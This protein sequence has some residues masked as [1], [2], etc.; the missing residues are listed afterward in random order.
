MAWVAVATIGGAAL[1]AWSSNKSAKDANASQERQMQQSIDAQKEATKIDPRIEAMLYGNGQTTQTLKQG[2]IPHQEKIDGVTRMVYSPDDYETKT[3]SG[4]LGR[5]MGNLDKS[6]SGG[7]TAAGTAADRY[8]SSN[9]GADLTNIRDASNRLMSGISAPQMNAASAATAQAANNG[10]LQP[11][12]ASTAQIDMPK[13]Y[14]VTKSDLPAAMNAAQGIAAQTTAPQNYSATLAQSATAASPQTMTAAQ[15]L[16]SNVSPTKKYD[17]ATAAPVTVGQTGIAAPSQN[18]LDLKDAYS[19]FINAESGNNP[20]LTGAI[21]KGINQSNNAYGNM[22]Q[23]Q[24]Q[25]VQDALSSIRGGAISSGQYGGSRQGLAESRTLADMSKNLTRAASQYG[26]NNTDAAVAAQAGQYGQ[27]QANKLS[28]LT[29]LGGQ[30]YS[31]AAQNAQMEQAAKMANAQMAM[32]GNQFNAGNQNQA[33]QAAFGNEAQANM[34][35]AAAANS[36][37]QF[38]ANNQ[39][40][41]NQANMQAGQNNAQFNAGQQQQANLTNAA[42]QNQAAQTGYQGLL[43]TELSNT[44]AQNSMTQQNIG[45][46]QNANQTN[47]QGALNNAQYNAAA[48]NQAAQ[49]GYQGNLAASTANAN[50]SNQMGQF[51]AGNQQNANNAMYQGNLQNNQFNAG[52]ANQT[53]Q[54]NATN[55]Q[56]AWGNNLQAQMGTNAQNSQNAMSGAGLLSGQ[57]SNIYNLSNNY[58]NADMAR[59]GQISGLLQPYSGK[60]SPINVPQYQQYTSNPFGSAIGGATAAMG[61]YNA[62]NQP[63]TTTTT[64]TPTNFN[65]MAWVR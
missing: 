23:D 19:Q 31:I 11:S 63:S 6:Q 2:A 58:N 60:G 55:Q 24:T 25:A 36:M 18:S 4:L 33:N 45:N 42:A 57:M 46:Q 49:T 61:L 38:N 47:Y 32:A 29:S 56:N 30:Q 10:Y 15:G 27:D 3:D 43:N 44:A 37:S 53:N 1:G 64:T 51:N 39:N 54:Y 65:P 13:N 62:F 5:I 35:N 7:L 41:A 20:Y 48:Q 52:L 9:Y 12:Y 28:A 16:L 8:L 17:V 26:Q 34:A 21:Q 40:Q 22:I 14:D 50:M 59:Y